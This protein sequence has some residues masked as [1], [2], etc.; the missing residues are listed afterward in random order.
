MC[1]FLQDIQL[2]SE[3]PLH[4]K[5]EVWQGAQEARYESG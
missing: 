3:G 2:L 5:Q 1:V 4:V